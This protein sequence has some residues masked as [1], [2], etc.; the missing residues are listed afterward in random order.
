MRFLIFI[1]IARKKL[2]TTVINSF[3]R[4]PLEKNVIQ[5]EDQW[6]VIQKQLVL[7]RGFGRVT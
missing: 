7:L 4:K 5:D 2:T 1:I 3:S 6:P